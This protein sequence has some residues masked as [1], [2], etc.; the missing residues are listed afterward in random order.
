MVVFDTTLALTNRGMVAVKRR[1]PPSRTTEKHPDIAEEIDS[2]PF[3]QE[4]DISGRIV[5]LLPLWGQAV[6]AGVVGGSTVE[7]RYCN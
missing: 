5:Y 1:P 7:S 3:P 2:F 4:L 6:K